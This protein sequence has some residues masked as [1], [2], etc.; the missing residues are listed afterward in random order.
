MRQPE[1]IRSLQP[2][3]SHSTDQGPSRPLAVCSAIATIVS[4]RSARVNT[5]A[6]MSRSS[7]GTCCSLQPTL[8]PVNFDSG[9]TGQ[10]REPSQG[11]EPDRSATELQARRTSERF[12]ASRK[13]EAPHKTQRRGDDRA[14]TGGGAISAAMPSG[15][16]SDSRGDE[17]EEYGARTPYASH[18][19]PSPQAHAF[20]N[21]DARN[22]AFLLSSY[23]GQD[24]PAGACE[25][26]KKR[27]ANIR[28]PLFGPNE[29]V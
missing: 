1:A 18:E 11:A 5:F 22:R 14:I 12:Q 16:T 21:T 15:R 10:P 28:S 3:K 8:H 6:R 4:E 9:P 2:S 13:K 20:R 19:R 24:L 7:A 26:H 17:H 29:S 25:S 23:R 27:G